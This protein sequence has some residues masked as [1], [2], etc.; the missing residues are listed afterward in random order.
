MTYF[1]LPA[2]TNSGP[3]NAGNCILESPI[4]KISLGSMPPNPPRRTVQVRQMNLC[5]QYLQM[6]SET[7]S[8]GSNCW[9]CTNRN[10]CRTIG[11]VSEYA[12]H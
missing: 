3:G 8:V 2:Q 10:G 9:I 6:L 1:N 12:S 11:S 4:L 7:L 5:V